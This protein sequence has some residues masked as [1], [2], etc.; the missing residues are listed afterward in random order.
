M[1][2]Y[3]FE[4]IQVG[5]SESFQVTVTEQMMDAFREMTGD[6]NPLHS[7]E[8]YAIAKGFDKRVVYGMLTASFLSTLAGVYLPGQ[9]SLIHS[10]EFKCVKPVLAGDCLT[11][12]GTVAEKEE[13]FRYIKVKAVICNQKNEKVLRGMMQIGVK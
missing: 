9:K 11:V 13:R 6:E 10:V 5:M 1:N 3:E 8:Q 2:R 4:E 12:S 7:D